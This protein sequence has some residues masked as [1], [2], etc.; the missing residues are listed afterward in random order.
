MIKL[1]RFLTARKSFVL[2]ITLE[3]ISIILIIKTHNYAQTKTHSLQTAI[4]GSIDQKLSAINNYFSLQQY[5][6]SLLQ[7]NAILLK[8]L[9]N[10]NSGGIK[11]GI[12]NQ[13]EVIPAYALSNQYNLNH[14]SLII[15]RGHDDGVLPEMGVVGTNGVIGIIQKTSRHYAR[16]ISILNKNTKLNVALA[17]TNYTGFLQWKSNNPNL[18]SVIDMPENAQIKIGDTIVTSGVS[19]IFPKGIPI[20][21]IIDFET[22]PGRKSYKIN[23]ETFMDMTNIGP[24]YVIKNRYK[25][26]IDSLKIKNP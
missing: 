25:E 22:V 9:T 15:N 4:S 6:D 21:R 10:Q 12:L 13:Y 11:P 17:H 14:N 8:A 2:F 5:N 7:Q 18:F 16:V 20:G 19:S 23:L 3:L 26:E 24:V 1:L